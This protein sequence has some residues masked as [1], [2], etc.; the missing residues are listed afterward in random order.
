MK[1]QNFKNHSRFV[2]GYHVVSTLLLCAL[3]IGSIVNLVTSN[4]DNRY[5]ASLLV[6]ST[7]VLVLIGF[8]TRTFA[9]IAQDR[10]IKAEENLRYYLLTGKTLDAKLK[11]RQIIGLR[12]ASDEEFPA[13][14]E[15]ALKEKLSEKDIKKSIINWRPD[16]Y[17]V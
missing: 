11:V 3:L 9:L 6:L 8:Y 15:K 16:Y 7:I 1:E 12:F 17:R 2:T 13:L 4:H 5:S 14:V 10:V